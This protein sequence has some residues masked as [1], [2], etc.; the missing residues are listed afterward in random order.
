[1]RPADAMLKLVMNPGRSDQHPLSDLGKM[2]PHPSAPLRNADIL[3]PA[4]IGAFAVLLIAVAAIRSVDL[5]SPDAVSY[6]RVAQYYAQGRWDLA[7]NAYWGPLLSWLMIPFLSEADKGLSAARIVM[8][9]SAII[10]LMA[11]IRILFVLGLSRAQVAAGTAL[12]SLF[13]IFWAV[14]MITPDLLMN[15]LFSAGSR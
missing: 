7:V 5:F 13:A 10:F 2:S 15:G 8:A 6:L 1:M 11:S 12:V 4:C 9:L 3:P 14:N